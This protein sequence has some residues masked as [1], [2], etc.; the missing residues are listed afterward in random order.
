MF[1]ILKQHSS[2]LLRTNLRIILLFCLYSISIF[3]GYLQVHYR[4]FF[5]VINLGL[6]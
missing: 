6:V 4:L 1:V 2:L 5:I 3:C